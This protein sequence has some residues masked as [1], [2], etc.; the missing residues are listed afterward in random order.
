MTVV[1]TGA[2]AAV[3]LGAA[4]Y[5]PT[6]QP[7]DAYPNIINPLGWVQYL[8]SAVP[9]ANSAHPSRFSK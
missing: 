3:L 8:V 1:R 6:D 2:F 5:P 7:Y 4:G 9:S